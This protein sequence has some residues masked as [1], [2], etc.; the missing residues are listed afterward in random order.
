VGEDRKQ[1]HEISDSMDRKRGRGG[2]GGGLTV[3]AEKL[4][5]PRS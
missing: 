5:W 4:I 2:G 1:T 3:G